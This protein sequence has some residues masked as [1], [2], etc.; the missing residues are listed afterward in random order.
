[1]ICYFHPTEEKP[2]SWLVGAY[3]LTRVA[4]M[5]GYSY[6]IGE[7]FLLGRPPEDAVS[8]SG[9]WKAWV[10]DGFDPFSLIR[11]QRWLT[12]NYI[13]DSM[14]RRWPCPVVLTPGGERA[15]NVSYDENWLPALTQEQKSLL[16]TAQAARAA[17]ATAYPA[18][19][20]EVAANA[21]PVPAACAW[22]ARA[23]ASACHVTPEV[24]GKLHLIDDFMVM[25]GL[26][27]VT[28]Y[29]IPDATNE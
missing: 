27:V 4:F 1:M 25:A 24:L 14:G 11:L 10:M 7:G 26:E 29:T 8:L 9:G 23:L 13:Q 15:F 28:G 12:V 2:P 21:L 17:L 19:G 6:G 5:D 22:L 18:H 20:S 3:A 16:E